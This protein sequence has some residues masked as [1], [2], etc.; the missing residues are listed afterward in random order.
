MVYNYNCCKTGGPHNGPIAR[1]LFTA[2]RG[3]I[4]KESHELNCHDIMWEYHH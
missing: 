1:F 3:Y 4:I 2:D